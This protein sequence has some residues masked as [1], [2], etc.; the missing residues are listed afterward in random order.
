MRVT[1]S[2]RRA[3]ILKNLYVVDLRHRA[4]FAELLRPGTDYV[5]NVLWLHGGKRQV[6]A[7]READYAAESGFTFSDNQSAIFQIHPVVVNGGFKRGEIIIEDECA[8]IAR[9]NY[10]TYSGISRAKVAG[11]VIFWFFV[12]RNL[13]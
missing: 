5:F 6:V 1:R 11:R 8:G 7:W 4:Q 10:P 12:N 13:L 3:A 2:H 9:V